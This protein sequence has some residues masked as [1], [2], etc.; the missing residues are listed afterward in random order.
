MTLSFPNVDEH[1]IINAEHLSFGFQGI[2]LHLSL[3]RVTFNDENAVVVESSYSYPG[4][5][6]KTAYFPLHR[7]TEALK[8]HR[9]FTKAWKAYLGSDDRNSLAMP[10][11]VCEHTPKE[12]LALHFEYFET[13][14]DNTDDWIRSVAPHFK[15]VFKVDVTEQLYHTD[16]AFQYRDRWAEAGIEYRFGVL[17]Y[18]MSFCEPYLHSVRQTDEGFVDPCD[19]VIEQFKESRM[20]KRFLVERTAG[21]RLVVIY[22]RD[23]KCQEIYTG[24][25][26]TTKEIFARMGYGGGIVSAVDW[27]D[28]EI[29][30]YSRPYTHDWVQKKKL[31]LVIAG[32]QQYEPGYWNPKEPI[33]L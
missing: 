21:Q 11:F 5:V 13:G 12:A 15:H 25:T 4:T 33:K 26:E 31:D 2:K 10:E 17:L 3:A 30:D 22:W 24:L 6:V 29:V 9:D 7:M 28:N 16:K 18:L 23:G 32:V 1:Y 14:D 8:H 20:V 19:W 27:I